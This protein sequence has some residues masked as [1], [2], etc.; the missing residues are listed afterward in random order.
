ME[1]SKT[2]LEQYLSNTYKEMDIAK[3]A[4]SLKMIR[5]MALGALLFCFRAEIIT[6]Q[7]RNLLVDKINLEYGIKWRDLL[8]EKALDSRR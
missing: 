2:V 8:K 7:D 5:D 6:D 3:D 4:E 1:N